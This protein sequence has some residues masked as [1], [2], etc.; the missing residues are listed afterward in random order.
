[1]VEMKEKGVLFRNLMLNLLQKGRYGRWGGEKNSNHE[2][3]WGS[4]LHPI[5]GPAGNAKET[6]YAIWCLRR[7]Y[8]KTSV[9]FLDDFISAGKRWLERHLDVADDEAHLGDEV[10]DTSLALLAL[11]GG[12]HDKNLK[13]WILDAKNSKG[14]FDGEI[15]ETC[16]AIKA[17]SECG[18]NERDL[19]QSIEWL[20]DLVCECQ[21]AG[22]ITYKKVVSPTYTALIFETLYAFEKDKLDWGEVLKL[23]AD[24]DQFDKFPWADEVWANFL[25][26]SFL[27]RIRSEAKLDQT[28]IDKINERIEESYKSLIAWVGSKD[29]DLRVEDIVFSIFSLM[30]CFEG[31]EDLLGAEIREIGPVKLVNRNLISIEDG[32]VLIR[33]TPPIIAALGLL[34]ASLIWIDELTSAFHNLIGVI[35]GD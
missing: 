15:W 28:S 11:A 32:D 20:K 31:K 13:A 18:C 1:M 17:L 21:D 4:W 6:A 30:S 26:V 16:F 8:A 27:Q 12:K 22:N 3:V 24:K 10:W 35:K 19:K 23:F 14:A 34:I 29:C 25:V 9:D 7:V 5:K 33:L 2:G